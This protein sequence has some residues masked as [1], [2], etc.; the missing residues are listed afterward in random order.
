MAEETHAFSA[1]AI[2]ANTDNNSL[3]IEN[4]PAYILGWLENGIAYSGKALFKSNKIFNQVL[5]I[6]L[7]IDS[8]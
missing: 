2:S 8:F 6:V 7:I 1:C 5:T 3:A 4:H